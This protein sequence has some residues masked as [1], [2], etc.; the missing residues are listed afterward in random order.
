MQILQT[1]HNLYQKSLNLNYIYTQT[2]TMVQV[3]R[4]NNAI[5]TGNGYYYKFCLNKTICAENNNNDYISIDF[6][7]TG[8]III[9]VSFDR[10]PSRKITG[11]IYIMT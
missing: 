11:N 4:G 5:L 9:Y 7:V 6:N 2:Q 3:F 1:Q 8:W 10:T